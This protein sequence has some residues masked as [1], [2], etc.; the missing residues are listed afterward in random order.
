MRIVSLNVDQKKVSGIWENYHVHGR[1]LVGQVSVSVRSQLLLTLE[2]KKPRR[3]KCYIRAQTEFLLRPESTRFTLRGTAPLFSA[4]SESAT[5]PT[6]LAGT[7]V[8]KRKNRYEEERYQLA[9]SLEV[10]RR[11]VKYGASLED[12]KIPCLYRAAA[13]P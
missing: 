7:A 9:L 11:L 13:Q 12:P 2:K 6:I 1:D 3:E 10:L 5:E 8:K 4:P